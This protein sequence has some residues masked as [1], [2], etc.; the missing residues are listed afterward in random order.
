[1]IGSRYA[2]VIVGTYMADSR[3]ACEE[4]EKPVHGERRREE[5]HQVQ[6]P[7]EVSGLDRHGRFFTESTN[8]RDVS[9]HGCRFALRQEVRKDAVVA[10][11]LA[12]QQGE[13]EP[14]K[15]PVLFQVAWVGELP[16]GWVLG[17]SKV[18]PDELWD[19]GLSNSN[20]RS[21]PAC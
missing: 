14:I 12:P 3:L 15:W 7:I 2:L 11:R 6:L 5:R 9:D 13:Q 18:Q 19:I 8:T 21:R 17:A 4:P 1:M 10:I 20:I 16:E